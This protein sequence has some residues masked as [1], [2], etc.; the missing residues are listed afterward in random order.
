MSTESTAATTTTA[1]RPRIRAGAI[2]WGLVVAAL[3]VFLLLVA[4]D[5]ALRADVVDRALA[6]GQGGATALTIAVLGGIALLV[7]LVRVLDRR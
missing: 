4:S 5:T 2:V 3:S 1:Q 7:G 6:L